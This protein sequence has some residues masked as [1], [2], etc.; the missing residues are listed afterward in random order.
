MTDINSRR[1]FSLA[2]PLLLVGC[3]AG[4]GE[5]STKPRLVVFGESHARRW[6]DDNPTTLVKWD[7]INRGIGGE[8]TDRGLKRIPEAL[9]LRPNMFVL[10]QGGNDAIQF[11]GLNEDNYRSMLR[12]IVASGVP[13]LVLTIP[14]IYRDPLENAASIRVAEAQRRLASEEGVPLFD[15]EPL[16]NR[17][18]I[19]DDGLH[20]NALGYALVSSHLGWI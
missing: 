11:N 20:L 1:T 4:V 18:L 10:W 9:A 13:S 19:L 15:V 3:G 17:S 14:Q 2:L 6:C 16:I 5:S 7:F 12:L 8:T